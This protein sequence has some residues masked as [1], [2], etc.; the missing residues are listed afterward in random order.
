MKHFLLMLCLV[1]LP[2]RASIDVYQFDSPEQEQR[3]RQLIDDLRCPKCQNQ[4]LSGSDAEVAKDLKNRAYELMKQGKTDDEIRAYLIDR[5][6]D[7]IS[8]RP[9]VRSG[10]ALLWFGP[11]L[12]FLAVGTVLV[13][14]TRR[15]PAVTAPMSAE[16]REKLAR[17]LDESD[18]RT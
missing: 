1:V 15:T 10:T 13:W 18:P 16:E 5:Y 17:L 3:F 6:G 9:P 8:Y 7:F 2:V 12:L 14:R 11:L 4:N